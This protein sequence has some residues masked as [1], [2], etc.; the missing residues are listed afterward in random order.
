LGNNPAGIDEIRGDIIRKVAIY[1]TEPLGNMIY[2]TFTQGLFPT[3]LKRSI[4]KP[5]HKR[6]EKT[7]MKNYRPM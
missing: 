4:I 5:I 2:A 3:A 6:G 7:N 1:I